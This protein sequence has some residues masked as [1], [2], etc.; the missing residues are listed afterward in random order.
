MLIAD[1]QYSHR[2]LGEQEPLID[3]PP[4]TRVSPGDTCIAKQHMDTYEYTLVAGTVA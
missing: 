2:A 3:R 4:A 1:C